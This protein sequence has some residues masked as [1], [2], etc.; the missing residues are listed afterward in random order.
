MAEV[1][2]VADA[3]DAGG[4]VADQIARLIGANPAAVLGLATGST[5]LP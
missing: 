1:I 5:P 3:A 4:L 2:I